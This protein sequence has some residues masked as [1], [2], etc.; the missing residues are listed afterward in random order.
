MAV[1]SG[2][3][4]QFEYMLGGGSPALVTAPEGYDSTGWDKGTFLLWD[5]T[6]HYE[7]AASGELVAPVLGLAI[8]PMTS[9]ADGSVEKPFLLLTHDT[10]LSAVV[11]HN[12]TASAALQATNFF[13]SYD[14]TSSA[15]I[16]P[17]TNVMVIDLGKAA[18]GAGAYIIGAKDATGTAY[19]RA[20]FV[21]AGR[22]WST[23]H[24]YNCLVS[25]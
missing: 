15:T 22:S 18:T 25:T 21:M 19:G 24:P 2:S 20:Y 14:L 13:K 11:A 10:V 3:R 6:G 17:S 23:D 8:S 12:T 5:A 4:V 16:C 9:T 7:K 1:T